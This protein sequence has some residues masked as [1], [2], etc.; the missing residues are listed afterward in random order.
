MRS[1]GAL[2]AGLALA[3]ASCTVEYNPNPSRFSSKAQA[4]GFARKFFERYCIPKYYAV[5]RWDINDERLTFEFGNGRGTVFYRDITAATL[6]SSG[7][8]LDTPTGGAF[9]GC[10]D[11]SREEAA[12]FL[13]ALLYLQRLN[14][15]G[16]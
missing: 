14:R 12:H 8:G 7:V 2:C 6:Y 11:A 5:Y 16:L 15:K 1:A 3:V 13:D 9:V 10:P 4:A